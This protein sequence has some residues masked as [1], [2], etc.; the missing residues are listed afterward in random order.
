MK[1]NPY[2]FLN[3]PFHRSCTWW[4]GWI[5]AS[6][7]PAIKYIP[8]IY[9]E[10]SGNILIFYWWFIYTYTSADLFEKCKLGG[11]ETFLVQSQLQW[12]GYVLR[13]CD[14]QIP[15]DSMYSQLHS[16]KRNVGWPWIRYKNKMKSTVEV[17]EVPLKT[18]EQMALERKELSVS[19]HNVIKAFEL[20]CYQH[21]REARVKTKQFAL[22]PAILSY[23]PPSC[24]QWGVVCMSFE[25]WTEV[26]YLT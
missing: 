18:F 24:T 21:L 16:S 11:I 3:L 19:C 10:L 7:F 15:K 17:V 1:H 20:W 25:E 26:S 12:A 2:S 5:G 13:I 4:D 14:N 8:I 22:R 23:K 9:K 6:L